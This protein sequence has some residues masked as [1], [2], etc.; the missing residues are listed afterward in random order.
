MKIKWIFF[1]IGYTLV[2]EDEP[3]LRRVREQVHM[4]QK[5]GAKKVTEED[6]TEAI[7]RLSGQFKVKYKRI[8]EDEFGFTEIAPYMREYETLYPEVR[9]ELDILRGNYKLGIVAN[10]SEGLEKRLCKYG[11][12]EYFDIIVS[13]YDVGIEK[14]DP[15]IFRLAIEQSGCSPEETVM[16]G[17][18]IDNDIVPAKK[19]GM[20]T[21]R[22]VKGTAAGQKPR[23][24]EEEP[25]CTVFS[26]TEVADAINK[27]ENN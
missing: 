16:V 20:R 5:P 9:E 21:V 13:S 15:A 25:D 11:I 17:D 24:A 22:I 3:L 1:D 14:P 2:N 19:A 6:I 23:S 10:Q 7:Y 27:I 12:R 18:R 26:I 8:M 4:K